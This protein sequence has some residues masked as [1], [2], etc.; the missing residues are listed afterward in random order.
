[1]PKNSVT[2]HDEILEKRERELLRQAT[3]LGDG[4]YKLQSFWQT[5]QP[6]NKKR[7]AALEL[8]LL[9][10]IA[11]LD[12]VREVRRLLL[13]LAP[14]AH[15]R[16]RDIPNFVAKNPDYA[17]VVACEHESGLIVE[18]VEAMPKA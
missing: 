1:M 8:E 18:H 13:G 4:I 5:W 6:G 14:Q 3:A 10:V 7:R 9:K 17:S 15:L 12:E 11:A 16:K 2:N